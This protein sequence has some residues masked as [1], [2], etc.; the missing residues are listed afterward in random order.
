MYKI[1]RG[2]PLTDIT[3]VAGEREL[4]RSRKTV[5]PALLVRLQGECLMFAVQP[6]PREYAPI[7]V[8]E[9]RRGCRDRPNSLR[10][11]P[12]ALWGKREAGKR[13]M[14]GRR[15]RRAGL[16]RRRKCARF[17]RL[18]LN[19]LHVAKSSCRLQASSTSFCGS[20]SL[21]A[22]PLTR[23]FSML[24]TLSLSPARPAALFFSASHSV[25]SLPPP[26]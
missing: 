15:A 18:A 5:R 11:I 9:Q 24:R 10:A 8:Q 17:S 6:D 2:M 22:D 7:T 12:S 14:L 3:N 19:P 20:S 4:P 13:R 26:R 23:P 25:D 21:S 16:D 1:R